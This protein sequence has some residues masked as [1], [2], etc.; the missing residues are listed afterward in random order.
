MDDTTVDLV[1]RVDTVPEHDGYKARRGDDETKL[2][3]A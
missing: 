3:K 1:P 2:S